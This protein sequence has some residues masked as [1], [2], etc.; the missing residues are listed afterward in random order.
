VN[1]KMKTIPTQ[2]R[3]GGDPVARLLLKENDIRTFDE[4]CKNICQFDAKI[5]WKKR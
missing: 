4:K 3:A 2:F 1:K 5:P